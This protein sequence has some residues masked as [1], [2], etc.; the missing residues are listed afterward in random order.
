MV[1]RNKFVKMKREKIPEE[2]KEL[3]WE[4]YG[5]N[6]CAITGEYDEHIH[7]HHL[8]HDATDNRIENLLPCLYWIHAYE[9][10]PKKAE[11]IIF[12]HEERFK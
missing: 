5:E 2:L 4:I 10:H 11:E 7:I 1:E 8:N 9:Y 12:W 3:L 6:T